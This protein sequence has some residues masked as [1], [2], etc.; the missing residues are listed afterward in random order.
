MGSLLQIQLNILVWI[1][2]NSMLKGH[3]TAFL[4]ILIW[5]T[6]FVSTKVLLVDFSPL[7][8]LLYRFVIGL[9][10]L[11]IAYPHRLKGTTV[12]QEL[13]FAAAGL[14]GVTM[15]YLSENIALTY[16]TA[17]NVGVITS[18][19]PFFVAILAHLFLKGESL[20]VS[21]LIGFIISIIGIAMISFNGQFFF[22]LN[23]VGDMLALFSAFVWGFYSVFARK[24][25]HWGYNTIQT[26]RRIFIYGILFMLP[27][28]FFIPFEFGFERF[29]N[30]TNLFNMLFLAFG[31]SALCFVTWNYSVKIIGAVKTS[32][33]IYMV[34]VITVVLSAIVLDEKI[35]ALLVLGILLTLTGLLIS[36]R[37][38]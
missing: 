5:G 16:S 26:T 9:I 14:T 27:T 36:E 33:Y 2:N 19:A 38:K 4:T 8:I 30:F 20:K 31:A 17:S 25:S 32:V 18:T 22:E 15:Y 12:K 1:R 34:P 13:M 24:I 35:N 11:F 21:F 37:R 6:T 23:P 3:I 7:E 29:T 28:L 10:A